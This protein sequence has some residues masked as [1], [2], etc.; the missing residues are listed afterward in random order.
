MTKTQAESW[1]LYSWNGPSAA[2]LLS[3]GGDW[4][5]SFR[6]PLLLMPYLTVTALA[7]LSLTTRGWK[8][9][10]V[11][12]RL[13]SEPSKGHFDKDWVGK[14]TNVVCLTPSNLHFLL[15]ITVKLQTRPSLRLRRFTRTPHPCSNKCFAAR[16][17]NNACRNILDRCC[18]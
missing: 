1:C 7:E 6:P 10:D 2:Y 8:A 16:S 18:L 17:I 15:I 12:I 4:L 9:G 3:M 11:G 13:Q 14:Q 5:L